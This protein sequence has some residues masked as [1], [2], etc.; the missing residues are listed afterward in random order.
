MGL[1]ASVRYVALTAAASLLALTGCASSGAGSGPTAA[2]TPNAATPLQLIRAAYTTTAAAK[3]AR[4]AIITDI[5]GVGDPAPTTVSIAEDF[6]HDRLA[7]IVP[8]D[9]DSFETRLIGRDVYVKLPKE[10]ST[11]TDSSSDVPHITKPWVHISIP[12][13]DD[14]WFGLF[15][16][17]RGSVTDPT[18]YVKLLTDASSSV[19]RLGTD[20]VRGQQ[21]THYRL[22]LDADEIAKLDQA[23]G[24]CEASSTETATPVDVW[25]DRQGRLTRMKTSRTFPPASGKVWSSLPT[26]VPGSSPSPETPTMTTTIEVYDYGADLQVTPPPTDQVQD[27]TKY[28]PKDKLNSTPAPCP[29]S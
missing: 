2:S 7:E 1:P 29:R 26:D 22:N 5:K 4:L 19:T 27:V 24:T 16:V 11:S 12:R 21:S 17:L 10:Q 28:I 25:L 20:V 23:T 14:S 9:A 3:T 15:S 18:Q 13:T 6:A 8:F